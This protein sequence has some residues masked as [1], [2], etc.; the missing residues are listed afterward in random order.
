MADNPG[1]VVGM[2]AGTSEPLLGRE[3]GD[4]F[5]QRAGVPGKLAGGTGNDGRNGH[6]GTS[7]GDWAFKI[8]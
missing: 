3:A 5:L 6:E 4:G 7:D 1:D 2:V 8:R